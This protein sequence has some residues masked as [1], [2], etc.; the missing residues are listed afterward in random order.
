MATSGRVLRH[1]SSVDSPT[2]SQRDGEVLERALLVV[3]EQVQKAW[4][5]VDEMY[6]AGLPGGEGPVLAAK[7]LRAHLLRVKGDL[8]RE[9]ARL[10]LDCTR[11]GRQVHWV[12]GVGS[13]PGHWG[14]AEPAP[15]AHQPSFND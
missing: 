1:P 3:A 12:Q 2:R 7:T 11:C 4:D 8:E 6:V 9:L 15:M 5:L 14:H 10:L 13:D